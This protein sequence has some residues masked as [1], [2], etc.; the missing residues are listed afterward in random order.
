MSSFRI[1]VNLSAMSEHGLYIERKK[2]T[3]NPLCFNIHFA[4]ETINGSHITIMTAKL[5]LCTNYT[6][7][8][9]DVFCNLLDNKLK[10]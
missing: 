7:E 6:P 2:T 8:L 9:C 5:R 1:K 3:F 10:K 4:E